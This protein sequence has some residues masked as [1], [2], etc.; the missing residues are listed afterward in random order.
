[1]YH[2]IGDLQFDPQLLRVT[3]QHF[4]EHLEILCRYANPISL[5]ELSSALQKDKIPH[6][7]VVITFDDGYIDNLQYAKPL[8]EHH[9]IPAT[10][11]VTAGQIGCQNE[12]WWDELDR[13]LLLPGK[14]P[15]MLRLNIN[16]SEHYWDTREAT[17]YTEEE[18]Q[19]YQ[20]WHIEQTYDPSPRHR[21]YRSIYHLLHPL[22]GTERQGMIQELRTWANQDSRCRP[23]HRTLGM[24]EVSQL[25]EGGLIE[26]GAH[27]M[28]HPV[29]ADLPVSVQRQEIIQS[30]ACLEEILNHPVT[31]FSYPHGSY[32]HKTI[33]L[34]KEAGF[35]SACSSDP[36]VISRGA[37]TFRLP[38]FS[39][40]DWNGEEFYRW[41][42][43]LISI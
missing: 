21:F 34:V 23:S 28:T 27:T 2:R 35:N 1:M 30:K 22:N 9:D 15:S 42:K 8:L 36:A 31:S 3:L 4:D 33:S 16:G 14:L 41:L 32:A 24:D 6:H 18:Y 38:R 37:D 17:D 26:I 20:D 5:Q 11:F 19:H 29:L 43:R 25:A 39:M 40:R 12:F 13:L 7:G 10:I